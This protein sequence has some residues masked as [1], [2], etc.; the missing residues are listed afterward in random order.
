MK[1]LIQ[2]L[3][4]VETKKNMVVCVMDFIGIVILFLSLIYADNE[5]SYDISEDLQKTTLVLITILTIFYSIL[6]GLKALFYRKILIVTK[7]ISSDSSLITTK[8][9]TVM[10]LYF[11]HPN[12][13]LNSLGYISMACYPPHPFEVKVNFFLLAIQVTIITHELIRRV[14]VYTFMTE[15]NKMIMRKQRASQHC[16]YFSL[17]Y[18]FVEHPFYVLLSYLVFSSLYLS[19]LLKLFESPIELRDQTALYYW[20]NSIWTS[21]VTMLTI[22]YGD[23]FP[24]TYL[25]RTVSVITGIV[26]FIIFSLFVIAINNAMT[27]KPREHKTYLVLEKKRLKRLYQERAA[28]L[29]VVFFKCYLSYRKRQKYD[30][31]WQKSRLSD[32][33]RKFRMTQQ[34]F[35]NKNILK[36][37]S[38]GPTHAF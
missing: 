29:I 8:V 38:K 18:L 4:S 12:Y 33:L 11:I 28:T 24:V 32:E 23:V 7:Y 35:I 37:F 34:K 25:G 10:L 22:G 13:L 19:L 2:E 36:D 26:G 27:F 3:R 31:R 9:V 21:F 16:F 14:T 15:E 30:Y 1:T 5:Y 6:K 20:S 17:K